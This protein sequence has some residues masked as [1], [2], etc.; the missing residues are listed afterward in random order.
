MRDFHDLAGSPER[1]VDSSRGWTDLS[2]AY[3][4]RCRDGFKIHFEAFPKE[5]F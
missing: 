5:V 4:I 3:V 2:N 1:F